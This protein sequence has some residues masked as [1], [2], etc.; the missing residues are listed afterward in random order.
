MERV[1]NL[2][3]DSDANEVR[4]DLLRDILENVAEILRVHDRVGYAIGEGLQAIYCDLLIGFIE[5]LGIEARAIEIL[6]KRAL[7]V[8]LSTR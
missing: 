1:H 8:L 4:D 3:L 2:L 6:L 7:R 5:L